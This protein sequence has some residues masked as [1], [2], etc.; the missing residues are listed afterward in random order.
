MAIRINPLL[1]PLDWVFSTPS[2]IAVLRA[3][4][5]SKEG[6]SGRAVARA[7]GINHQT[8]A[9]ALKRLEGFGLIQRQGSA[10]T[11]LLRLNFDHF[12]VHELLLP[13]LR[14][15]R[16]LM[17]QI[18]A[19]ILD[20][21]GKRAL[22]A[23]LFGSAARGDARP[24]SDIDLLLIVQ[25]EQKAKI[26]NAARQFSSSFTKK[27]GIRL[28]PIVLTLREAKNRIQ[29]A[30]QLLRNILADGIDVGVKDIHEV[31]T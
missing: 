24:G 6:M 31:L 25:A 12:L 26:V 10:Q 14:K 3:L 15:E 5:D 29:T 16:E 4:R 7:A 19:E 21:I 1:R 20:Q 9:L 8:C 18:R 22:G 27:F 13:A 2:H 17:A 30:D 28:S 23:R 11:Q